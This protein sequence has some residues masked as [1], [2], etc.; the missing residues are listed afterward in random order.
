A[1]QCFRG[2]DDRLAV[3]ESLDQFDLQASS[4]SQWRYDYGCVPIQRVNVFNEAKSLDAGR[5][6][7]HELSNRTRNAQ[8]RGGVSR[9]YCGPAVFNEPSYAFDIRGGGTSDK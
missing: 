8:P 4:S 1:F 5:H 9:L 7:A 3:A 2:P 6:R